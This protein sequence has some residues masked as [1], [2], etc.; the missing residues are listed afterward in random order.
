MNHVAGHWD[1]GLPISRSCMNCRLGDM[2]LPQNCTPEQLWQ[3]ESRI[4]QQ[5]TVIPK[6]TVFSQDAPFNASYIVKSGSV[7]TFHVNER[8]DEKVLGFYLPTEMFGLE[9]VENG[10]HTCTAVALE[11][12]IICKLNFANLEELGCNAPD[13]HHW[14][15]RTVSKELNRVERMTRCLSYGTAEERVVGFLLDIAA[16]RRA[17]NLIDHQF[18]LTM[19]RSDI[20]NFLGLALETVSRILTRLQR[21]QEISICGR[22][23]EI[24]AEESLN[25][26]VCCDELSPRSSMQLVSGQLDREEREA[27]SR[28]IAKFR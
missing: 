20:A 3:I 2:C 26:R 14:L 23:V 17:R 24:L 12:S 10:V 1:R 19:A 15:L 18:R 11:R 28:Y 13:L 25:K 7:K 5:V 16:R 22:H 6:A 27:D 21:Q 9:G 8:G 4:K